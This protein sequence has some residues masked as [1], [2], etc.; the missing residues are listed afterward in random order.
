MFSRL[1]SATSFSTASHL[2]ER[3]FRNDL[4]PH[5]LC[6]IITNFSVVQLPRAKFFQRRVDK[7]SFSRGVFGSPEP[8]SSSR[9]LAEHDDLK[10]MLKG[11]TPVVQLQ[12]VEAYRRGVQ[13]NTSNQKKTSTLHSISTLIIRVI[14][15]GLGAALVFFLIRSPE[16]GLGGGFSKIFDSSVA[17]FAD[18]VD[19][20]FS[21]VQGVSCTGICGIS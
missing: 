16:R 17:S 1:L 5:R 7:G 9:K 3:Y 6:K 2:S 21:D 11:Y 4:F 18:N 14:T 12:L 10:D 20:R 19:V 15:I 8:R 13:S